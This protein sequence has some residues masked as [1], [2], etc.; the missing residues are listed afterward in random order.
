MEGA[1]AEETLIH[2]GENS[3]FRAVAVGQGRHNME[4]SGAFVAVAAVAQ[5][6]RASTRWVGGL[7]AA[8]EQEEEEEQTMLLEEQQQTTS[9]EEE[10]QQEDEQTT[11]LE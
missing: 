10:E 1:E 7:V 5:A 6:T 11:L 9:L 2:G 8:A 3:D 4:H